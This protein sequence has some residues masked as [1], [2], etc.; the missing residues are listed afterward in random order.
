MAKD[1]IA[2]IKINNKHFEIIVDLE[3]AL[4]LRKGEAVNIQNVLLANEVYANSKTGAK[5]A[6]T[7]LTA[8]FGTTDVFAIADRIVKKGDI[9]LPKDYRDEQQENKRKKV[10]DFYARNAIDVKSGRPFTPQA[11]ESAM[12]QVGVNVDNRPI[13]QQVGAITEALKKVIPIKFETKKLAITIPVAYTGKAYGIVNE[14]KEKEDWLADGSLR[15]VINI[16]VGLQSEF[17]DK[18][19][20][21]THGAALSEEL[22]EK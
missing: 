22:K 5:P 19:N 9:Q 1:T 3:P 6:A 2:R 15:V 14:Y 17:Y 8:A 16:P 18:L 21:I 12:N 4:R 20:S 10:I 7:D 13:E 11:I